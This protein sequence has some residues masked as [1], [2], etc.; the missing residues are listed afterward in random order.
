M[1]LN[2]KGTV[3]C[4]KYLAKYAILLQWETIMWPPSTA[5][6][7]SSNCFH[8]SKPSWGCI[9]GFFSLTSEQFAQTP[10]SLGKETKRAKNRDG[11][12]GHLATLH[13]ATME[14]WAEEIQR[15]RGGEERKTRGDDASAGQTQGFPPSGVHTNPRLRDRPHAP[16][17]CSSRNDIH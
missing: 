7:F 4:S 11:R 10:Q 14:R 3:K 2:H 8:C 5:K 13:A 15:W 16:R 17:D 12:V 1:E 9:T 6:A